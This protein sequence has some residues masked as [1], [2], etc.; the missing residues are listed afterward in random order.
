MKEMFPQASEAELRKGVSLGLICIQTLGGRQGRAAKDAA[1]W[2]TERF[3]NCL[4]PDGNMKKSHEWGGHISTLSWQGW[5]KRPSMGKRHT[6]WLL[7]SYGSNQCT[8]MAQPLLMVRVCHIS[9]HL[10]KWSSGQCP[11][12]SIGESSP[13]KITLR[14]KLVLSNQSLPDCALLSLLK[15]FLFVFLQGH[16]VDLPE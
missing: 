10:L 9:A 3:A 2:I 8:V 6:L 11:W 1:K 7:I 4:C 12:C 14:A 5:P 16:S 13:R 15:C